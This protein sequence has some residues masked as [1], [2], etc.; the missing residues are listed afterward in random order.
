M[1]VR[2]QADSSFADVG[3]HISTRRRL[4]ESA[5]AALPG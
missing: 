3:V 4:A 2:A 5:A 1:I